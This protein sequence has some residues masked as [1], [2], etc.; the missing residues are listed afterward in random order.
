MGKKGGFI[1]PRTNSN[2]QSKIFTPRASLAALG[3][4]LKS[5]GLFEVI[6]NHVRIRQKTVKHTPIEKLTDAFITILSGAHGL[7][8]INTRLRSD[9]GV[10]GEILIF[11][12]ARSK[13][14]LYNGLQAPD[15]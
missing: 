11:V 12:T 8:E 13:S 1:V 14:I 6:G 15:R 9:I 7:V 4:K 5:L 10:P 3:V 2:P